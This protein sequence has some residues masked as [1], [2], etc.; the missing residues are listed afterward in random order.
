MFI[1]LGFAGIGVGIYIGEVELGTTYGYILNVAFLLDLV[2]LLGEFAGHPPRVE[3]ECV[4][5]LFTLGSRSTMDSSLSGFLMVSSTRHW[6]SLLVRSAMLEG[7]SFL[8]RAVRPVPM[9]RPRTQQ[10]RDWES[11]PKARRSRGELLRQMIA[12]SSVT[13]REYHCER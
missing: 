4:G 2:W 13:W 5:V 11:K 12:S 6:S 9:S 10:R 8:T 1:G 3:D 7:L